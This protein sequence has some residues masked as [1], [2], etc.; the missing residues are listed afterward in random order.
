ME[1]IVIKSTGSW[2]TVRRND[3]KK[4]NCKLKGQ[5]RIKGI[6]A[7][8]P[9]SVGDKVNFDILPFEETGLITKILTRSNYIIR[10]ATKLSKISHII[11]S[12]IDQAYLIVTLA[13][14]RTSMGFIDRFLITTEAYHIPANLIFNKIDI[15]DDELKK[16]HNKITNIYISAGYKCFSVSALRGDNIEIIKK[17]LKGKINLFAGHSGVGKSALINA[18]EPE[19]RIKTKD[20]SSYH[21]KGKHTTAFAEMYELSFGGFIIDTPGIKEFGLLDF[22]KEEIA[23]RFPEMRKYMHGCRFNNCT[24][25]HEPGCAVKIALEKGLI[26]R[27]R[28][29]NY[30]SI[31]NDDYF[32]KDNWN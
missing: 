1:G 7:T 4:F 22:K 14:P 12:N 28:Y 30:L 8:N 15:Y 17:V 23:E 20:I 29:N 31:L 11:A 2:S 26:S 9:I 10:K 21:K 13:E 16:L 24:H 18:I 3:G 19:F 6:K 5:F 27:S 32:D 25:V